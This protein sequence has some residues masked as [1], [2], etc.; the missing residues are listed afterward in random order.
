MKFL[1]RVKF[2]RTYQ[3][4]I[5]VEADS[6]EEAWGKA[7]DY[8]WKPEDLADENCVDDE[9]APGITVVEVELDNKGAYDE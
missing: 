1:A 2:S 5:S 6:E 9:R 4:D 8:Q 7:E 3:V